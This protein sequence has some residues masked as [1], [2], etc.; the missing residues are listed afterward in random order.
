[1]EVHKFDYDLDAH[2]CGRGQRDDR[3]CCVVT[4]RGVTC[5]LCLRIGEKPKRK[6]R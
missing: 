5:S 4:W 1:M 3:E 6:K 2:L